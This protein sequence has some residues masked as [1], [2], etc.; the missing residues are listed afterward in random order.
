MADS[1][2]LFRQFYHTYAVV[3]EILSDIIENN[4]SI[5]QTPSDKSDRI[6]EFAII[7]TSSEQLLYNPAVIDRRI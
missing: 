1:L 7:Q 2:I 5:H 3:E 6:R 4:S